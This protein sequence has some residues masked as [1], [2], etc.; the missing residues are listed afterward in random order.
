MATSQKGN[1]LIVDDTPDNLRLLSAMLSDQSYDVRSVK[2]GSAALMVVQASN[3]ARH[4]HAR[5]ERL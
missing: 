2:S 1:I 3:S 5:D 4:Q